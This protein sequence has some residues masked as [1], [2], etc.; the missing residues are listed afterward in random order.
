MSL[1]VAV[2]REELQ[3]AAQRAAR[4]EARADAAE[5]SKRAMSAQLASA[6]TQVCR[7]LLELCILKQ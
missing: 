7:L 5:D 2:L 3:S 1:C 4:S 6:E